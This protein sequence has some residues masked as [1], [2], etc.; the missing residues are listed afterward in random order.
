MSDAIV[1]ALISAGV[2]LCGSVASMVV[3][4]KKSRQNAEL[5]IYRIEQLEEKVAYHNQ[6]V[7]RVYQ[8]EGRMLE[9]E[10]DIRDFKSKNREDKL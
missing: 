3:S 8:L 7:E 9:A 10:H 2:S 5:T 4:A 1:V 6:V